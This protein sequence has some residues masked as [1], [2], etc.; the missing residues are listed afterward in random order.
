[1]PWEPGRPGSGP[2]GPGSPGSPSNPRSPGFPGW[3]TSPGGPWGPGFPGGPAGHG[4][5]GGGV[6]RSHGCCGGFPGLPVPPAACL[7]YQNNTV[8]YAYSTD[9]D[10]DT[11]HG[12][13]NIMVTYA[14]KYTTMANVRFDTKQEEE[15]E[16]HSDKKSLENSLNSHVPDPS[17]GYGNKETG[18]NLYTVLKKFLNNGEVSLCGAH[19]FIAVKRYPDES[20]VLD[21]ITQL[22][23]NHVMVYI[24]VD[25]ISS[26]GSNSASLYA[27]SYQTNGYCLFATGNDLWN[28][29]HSMVETLIFPYQFLAQN[30]LVSG[31]GRIEIP[32]FKTPTPPGHTNY[33]L[34]AM[35]IQNHTLDSSYVSM[36]YTIES[37]DGSYVYEFPSDDLLP[38]FGT[39]QTDLLKLTGSLLYKWTIDYHYNTDEPQ[40]IECRMY[41][42]D[43]NDFLP[44]PP[45]V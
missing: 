18:S 21:I 29:F 32:T 45:S 9:I 2:G 40:I 35:T 14:N 7:P 13:A 34:V 39:A 26:G 28:A 15:I 6:T 5:H 10:Y 24:G 31:S 12:G 17:L 25:S 11:F 43:Y 36:N 42:D 20:D 22:R 23:S 16:Y 27:V 41:S 37:T 19:V 3:P 38:L 44:L 30:F 4:E 1:M 33:G 8:L